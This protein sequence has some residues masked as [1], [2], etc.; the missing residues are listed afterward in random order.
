LTLFR[1]GPLRGVLALLPSIVL[2]AV[3]GV[4]SFAAGPSAGAQQ[5]PPARPPELSRPQGRPSQKHPEA[6][7]P[8]PPASSTSPKAAEPQGPK[9][10]DAPPTPPPAGAPG[11]QEPAASGRENPSAEGTCLGALKALYGEGVRKPEARAQLNPGDLACQVVEPVQISTLRFG[12]ATL[13]LEPAVTLS[14]EMATRAAAWLGDSVRPLARGTFERDLVSVRVGGGHECR[15]RNRAATGNVSEHATAR[16]LDIF[17]FVLSGES[18]G[19]V[20]SVEKPEND[21]Q[22]RFLGAVRQSGCGAFT[23][24]LGPGSDAAHANHLHFDIQ[25]RR[26]ASTRFCQ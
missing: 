2:C 3:A 8:A 26:S 13:T 22:R 4:P 11:G 20:V 25:A 10:S 5:G 15:R 18:E 16:A 1:Y 9:P 21:A 14:C 12:S 17:A 19:K 7:P 24:S 6:N 23:T